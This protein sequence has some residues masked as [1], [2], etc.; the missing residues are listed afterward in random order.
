[1]IAYKV[2]FDFIPRE[3]LYTENNHFKSKSWETVV[4]YIPGAAEQL[5]SSVSI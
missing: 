3:L 1:M 2:L 4:L 5:D